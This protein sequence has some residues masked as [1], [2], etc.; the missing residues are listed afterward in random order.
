MYLI[1]EPVIIYLRIIAQGNLYEW[2]HYPVSQISH[3]E[4]KL[5]HREG[6]IG[7]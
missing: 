6:A 7:S 5:K 2:I 1:V 4:V 3:E